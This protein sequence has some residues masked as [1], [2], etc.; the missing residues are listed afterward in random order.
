M[1][2]NLRETIEKDQ[3]ILTDPNATLKEK[4]DAYFD[5]IIS[6]R[7]LSKGVEELPDQEDETTSYE[8]AGA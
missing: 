7:L 2:E 5:R 8:A 4:R 3:A 1:P 6:R